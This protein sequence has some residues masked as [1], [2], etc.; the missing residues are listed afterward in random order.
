[1]QVRH[2]NLICC[3]S[4]KKQDWIINP[5]RAWVGE[6][7]AMYAQDFILTIYSKIDFKIYFGLVSSCGILEH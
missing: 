4:M 7:G 2:V 5:P 1:M 3:T 6:S